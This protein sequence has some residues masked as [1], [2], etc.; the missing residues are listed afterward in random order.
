MLNVIKNELMKSNLE[1]ALNLILENEQIYKDNVEF[2]NLKSILCIKAEEYEIAINH[3]ESAMSLDS[4]NVDINYN[5]AYVN[6]KIGNIEN[7]I[8]L[9][10]KVLELGDDEI[11]DEVID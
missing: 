8:E 6:Y 4:Y 9:Y 2:I 5:L 3:L 7:S 10:K 11:V 1:L